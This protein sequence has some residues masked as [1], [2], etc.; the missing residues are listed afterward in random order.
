MHSNKTK[1]NKL[2][3]K[4][5]ESDRGGID[6]FTL[7]IGPIWFWFWLCLVKRSN[8]CDLEAVIHCTQR[9]EPARES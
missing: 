3:Y 7:E 8:V 5:L 1:P 6:V 9:N 2:I 4:Y